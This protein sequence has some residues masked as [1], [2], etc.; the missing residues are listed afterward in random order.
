MRNTL[1]NARWFGRYVREERHKAG[2][3]SAKSFS[4]AI[5]EKTGVF[6]D[7]DTILLIERGERLPDVEKYYAIIATISN[8]N[9]LMCWQSWA[10]DIIDYCLDGRSVLLVA[11]EDISLSERQLNVFTEQYAHILSM[12]HET[13]LSCFAPLTAICDSEIDRVEQAIQK[14]EDA[15]MQSKNDDLEKVSL[16]KRARAALLGFEKVS[17]NIHM[18]PGL[19]E[20][21]NSLEREN[22]RAK[23][24]Q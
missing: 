8:S 1:F 3:K 7:K 17:N 15:T 2:F 14:L 22:H 6:I 12:S 23:P 9:S 13:A 19:K 20:Y 4:D 11:E 16:L 5:Q 24:A 21:M 18:F 10:D